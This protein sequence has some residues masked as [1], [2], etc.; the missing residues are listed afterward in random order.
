M[1]GTHVEDLDHT[2]GVG[3]NAGEIGAAENGV[4]QGVGL[5]QGLFGQFARADIA[6]DAGE[7]ALATQQHLADGDL[8]R[9]VAAILAKTHDLAPQPLGTRLTAGLV[10]RQ[11]NVAVVLVQLRHHKAKALAGQFIGP[12]A[13]HALDGRVHRFHNPGCGQHGDDAVAHGVE[14]GLHPCG[15]VAQSLL[16]VVLLGDV[17]KHQ[18]CANHQATGVADGRAAVGNIKF[19]AITGDQ[20]R[21]VGHALHGAVGQ[22]AGNRN[23][24]ARPG[25]L[26]Q[27][28]EHLVN[29]APLGLRAGPAGQP[30]G[31]RVEQG[32]AG[33]GI[34]GNHC[35]ANGVEGDG[36]LL[37]TGLQRAV[38]LLQMRVGG[39]LGFQQVPRLQVDQ[40]LEPLLRGAVA[41]VGEIQGKQ[42]RQ[43]AHTHD[44][45]EQPAQAGVKLRVV[46]RLDV[47]LDLDEAAHLA[48]DA[49]HQALALIAVD[50]RQRGHHVAAAPQGDGLLHLLHLDAHQGRQ[51]LHVLFGAR[52]GCHAPQGLH[53]Q[54][55]A[56]AHVEIGLQIAFVTGQRVAPL[57]RLGLGQR[58]QQPVPRRDDGAGVPAQVG[59]LLDLAIGPD[60]EGH[61]RGQER[62]HCGEPGKGFL[63]GFQGMW[64]FAWS[65]CLPPYT[66]FPGQRGITL[67]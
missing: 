23:R 38:G 48:A 18:H 39:G 51:G 28:V 9:E 7:I 53:M 10:M 11:G 41:G 22:H 30:L 35:I 55:H 26:G 52:V 5:A 67:A 46:L 54:L 1:L 13:K 45:G 62:Q 25:R 14:N 4:L 8:Q 12:V 16:R 21:V 19:T 2:L 61:S 17:A 6:Q 57:G 50:Q 37:L 32:D 29:G 66:R 36:E 60:G 43:H 24:G 59:C 47:G 15:A 27:D 56:I 34:G 20:H 31:H 44:A 49:L 40:I 63:G 65:N 64:A 33:G 42:D 3:G 58:R